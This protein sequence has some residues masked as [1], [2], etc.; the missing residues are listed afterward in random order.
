M[1]TARIGRRGPVLE[2]FKSLIAMAFFSN[3]PGE[4]ATPGSSKS[5]FAGVGYCFLNTPKF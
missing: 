2:V 4:Q 1:L 3:V 5:S